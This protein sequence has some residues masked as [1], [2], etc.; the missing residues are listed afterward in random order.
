M[1]RLLKVFRR[2]HVLRRVT[3]ADVAARLAQTQVK[4]RVSDLQA[5]FTA[6]AAGRHILNLISMSALAVH[7]PNHKLGRPFVAL[8]LSE[9][10]CVPVIKRAW[11]QGL[12]S[13]FFARFLIRAPLAPRL[14]YSFRDDRQTSEWARHLGC[15]PDATVN[16]KQRHRT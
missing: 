1:T 15:S 13:S 8:R 14:H 10:S 6:I 9:E 5:V 4:P 7:S 11:L 16:Q 3:A 2:V 12:E